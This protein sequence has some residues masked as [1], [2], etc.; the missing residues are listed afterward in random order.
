VAIVY[1]ETLF[2]IVLA[3][4]LLGE[5][6]F[7]RNAI[8]ALTGASLLFAW[9]TPTLE[10]LAIM[11]LLAAFATVGQLLLQGAAR[12]PGGLVFQSRCR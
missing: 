10:E 8:S 9:R 5:Q 3:P 2:V 4:V 1:S 6:L 7:L 12:G 11:A